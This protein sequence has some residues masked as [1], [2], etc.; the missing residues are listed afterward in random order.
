M[1]KSFDPYDVIISPVS[2]EKAVRLINE[3]NK[4]TFYVNLRA[5][6]LEIKR[7]VEEILDVKVEKVWTFITPSGKKKAYVKLKPEYKASDV[8]PKLG[9]LV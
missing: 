6:K 2:T 1:R 4:L 8:A 5:N 7:A 9:I 3:E